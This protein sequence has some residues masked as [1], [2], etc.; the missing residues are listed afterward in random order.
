MGWQNIGHTG[1]KSA[2]TN[3]MAEPWKDLTEQGGQFQP[4][5]YFRSKSLVREEHAWVFW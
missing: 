5:F 2:N 1:W 4:V 3:S